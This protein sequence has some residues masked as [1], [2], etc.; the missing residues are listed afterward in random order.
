VL[1]TRPLYGWENIQGTINNEGPYALLTDD[2]VY[3]TYSGGA[4]G[5]Y[6]YALGLLSIPRGSNYLDGNS[7]KKATAPVLSYYSIDGVYGPGHNSFFK[8]YDGDV[9][10]M[11]HGEV[12]IAP[13]DTRC[14][15]MHR[16]HFGKNNVPVFNM[17]KERDLDPAFA[18]VELKVNLL[19]RA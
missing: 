19:S 14:T 5:G 10:I 18:E 13:A 11:Y 4:A 6:T 12:K 8:D 16:V 15:A 7:W 17:S 9:M 1:L 3:I 2:M